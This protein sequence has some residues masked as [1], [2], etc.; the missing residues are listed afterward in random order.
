MLASERARVMS[1]EKS[2]ALLCNQSYTTSA[3]KE[4][5]ASRRVAFDAIFE[6]TQNIVEIRPTMATDQ[7]TGRVTQDENAI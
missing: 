5:G 4:S 7:R 2:P 6:N 1:A 3:V